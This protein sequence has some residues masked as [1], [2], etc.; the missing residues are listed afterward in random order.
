M[1]KNTS[2]VFI[3]KNKPRGRYGNISQKTY[4]QT[5]DTIKKMSK[6]EIITFIQNHGSKK[7]ILSFA[8]KINHASNP[9][10]KNSTS[11]T[12]TKDSSNSIE[13]QRQHI[14]F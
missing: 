1:I 11:S 6:D 12:Q 4:K 7:D 8:I 9:K 2:V 5:D 3:Q 10:D 14:Y 13:L